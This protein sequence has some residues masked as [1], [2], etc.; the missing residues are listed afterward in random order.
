MMGDVADVVFPCGI[1]LDRA[2]DELRMYYGAA[3]TCIALATARLSDL[4]DWLRA[5][6]DPTGD[7]RA[8]DRAMRHL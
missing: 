6:S 5:Q 4:L 8:G 1:T 7:D 2:T 3:D